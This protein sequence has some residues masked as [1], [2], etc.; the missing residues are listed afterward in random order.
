[1]KFWIIALVV[2]CSGTMHA[3]V[4]ISLLFGDKLNSGKIEF[5][6]E[7][8]LSLSRLEGL[9]PMKTHQNY[10]LGFYFDIKTKKP[11]WMISTGVKVKSTMGAEGLPVYSLQNPALDSSFTGGNITRKLNYFNVPIMLKYTFKNK[12]YAQCG[13]QLGLRYKATD[14]F[15]RKVI[16]KDD[17]TYKLDVKNKYHP[18]DGGLIGGIGYRLE[19]GYGMNF[20]FSYY[21][22]LV[23]A[24]VSDS[25]PNEYNRVFY[26]NAGIPIGKGK[27]MEKETQES[28]E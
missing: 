13:I 11:A 14:V 2:F 16:D 21:L 6:L 18:L 23:D 27:A 3:Q 20:S 15:T 8:G 24:R 9:D 7:G 5:G 25:G 28:G 10:N 12:I 22:G 17:L 19:K 4:L 26:L 1:M